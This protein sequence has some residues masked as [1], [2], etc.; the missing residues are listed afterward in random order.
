MSKKT[1][2]QRYYAKQKK[3]SKKDF[4]YTERED[5]TRGVRVTRV[6]L[7]VRVNS[8]ASQRLIE[9]S[10]S[11]SL[12]RWKMLTRIILFSL[13]KYSRHQ[14]GLIRYSYPEHLLNPETKKVKY[15]GTTGEAQINAR[16]TSTAWNKLEC[17]ST[18]TELS[19][20]RIIQFLILDYKPTP[21]H[22]REKQKERRDEMREEYGYAS[23]Y[24]TPGTPKSPKSKFV[25]Q[26]GMYVHRKGIP[27]ESWD[28]EEYDEYLK[29][30]NNLKCTIIEGEEREE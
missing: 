28:D 26:G 16:I 10:E 21:Q 22:V 13:P 24:L 25:N 23:D 17:H 8:D 2:H 1:K 18:A 19:K 11:E 4:R 30:Q 20:A 6:P 29:L 3:D 14:D 15:K 9:L 5:G 12:P 27:I 7:C